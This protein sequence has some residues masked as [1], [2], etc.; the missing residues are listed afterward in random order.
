[1]KDKL[2]KEVEA[3]L[4]GAHDDQKKSAMLNFMSREEGERITIDIAQKEMESYPCHERI[5]AKSYR[6]S[7]ESA[8]CPS[9]GTGGSKRNRKKR[10]QDQ[11]EYERKFAD[12]QQ[13]LSIQRAET[14]A[15]FVKQ[16]GEMENTLARLTLQLHDPTMREKIAQAL[17]CLERDQSVFSPFVTILMLTPLFLN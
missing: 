14:V 8:S 15:T 2:S 11:L 1:M 7:K 6:R 5:W 9:C 3:E 10:Q 4:V 13:K 16:E 17:A 12:F